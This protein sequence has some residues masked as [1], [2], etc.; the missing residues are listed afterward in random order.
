MTVGEIKVI[1]NQSGWRFV[2]PMP[3][4]KSPWLLFKQMDKRLMVNAET[5][6]VKSV[7]FH[8]R[9]K[10]RFGATTL[11]RQNVSETELKLIFNYPRVHTDKGRYL[12]NN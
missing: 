10:A 7:L 8:P 9:F 2:K 3:K 1:A 5:L 6:D 4:S 12:I 11:I